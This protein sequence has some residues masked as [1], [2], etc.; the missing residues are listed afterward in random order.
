[1][2]PVLNIGMWVSLSQEVRNKV[3]SI[4][5][6]PRSG[7]VEVIDGRIQTDGTTYEDLKFLT[8][9]KMQKY[10]GDTHTDFH[11][12]F[13]KVLV[14]VNEELNPIGKVDVVPPIVPVAVVPVIKKRGRPAK[15]NA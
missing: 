4:F 10:T 14:K 5:D 2:Q 9:E 13:D 3:R 1:M 11:K 12:L 15:T 7:N 8:V 6:I